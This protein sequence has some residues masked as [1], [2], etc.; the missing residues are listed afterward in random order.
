VPPPFN[1][2]RSTL[3]TAIFYFAPFACTHPPSSVPPF[4][5]K[6]NQ[7][8]KDIAGSDITRGKPHDVHSSLVA[9]KI[10]SKVPSTNYICVGFQPGNL[11]NALSEIWCCSGTN[12]ILKSLPTGACSYI[13]I[14]PSFFTFRKSVSLAFWLLDS[15]YALVH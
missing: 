3:E 15:P 1:I 7:S 10:L 5:L 11:L 6:Q 13:N 4:L 2:P 8:L 14:T 9:K 12:R